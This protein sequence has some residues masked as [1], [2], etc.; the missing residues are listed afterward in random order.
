MAYQI[1][2][3]IALQSFTKFEFIPRLLFIDSSFNS[4]MLQ[5]YLKDHKN[6]SWKM[7]R[8]CIR[9]NGTMDE[10][11]KEKGEKPKQ[12]AFQL[13]SQNEFHAPRHIEAFIEYN[14]P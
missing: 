3:K 11:R 1:R 14:I 13:T 6:G 7:S 12:N 9:S 5:I 8:L 4:K 2:V 10:R